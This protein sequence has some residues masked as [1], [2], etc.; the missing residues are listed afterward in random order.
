MSEDGQTMVVTAL[1]R[2][3]TYAD[4]SNDPDATDFQFVQDDPGTFIYWISS[5]E[6]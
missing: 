6:G 1:A 4:A 5:D 2:T 3:G